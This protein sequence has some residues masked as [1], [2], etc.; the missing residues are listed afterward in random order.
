MGSSDPR[1]SDDLFQTS[2]TLGTQ[3]GIDTH[4]EKTL[5]T[6]NK[7]YFFSNNL[8]KFKRRKAAREFSGLKV[9]TPAAK[10]DDLG[11]IPEIHMVEKN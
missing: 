7:K 3:G 11:M 8:L 9:K 2:Q 6:L 5:Y 1:R 4:A 10:P